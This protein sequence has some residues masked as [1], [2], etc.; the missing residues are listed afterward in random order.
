MNSTVNLKKSVPVKTILLNQF[1][2]SF[3]IQGSEETR[4]LELKSILLKEWPEKG[5][6]LKVIV[7]D[8]KDVP[9]FSQEIVPA[10]AAGVSTVEVNKKFVFYDHLT[11]LV[12][13]EPA[14]RVFSVEVNLA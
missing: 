5:G 2:T 4:S 10:Q 3:R 8:E 7:L 6:S 9:V 1:N 11:V 13:A 12:T 14:E